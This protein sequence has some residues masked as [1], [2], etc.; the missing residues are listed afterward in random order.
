MKHEAGKGNK[1]QPRNRFWQPLVVPCQP[2]ELGHPRETAL[3]HPSSGQQHKA[4]FRFW[5]F[6]HLQLNALRRCI[7]CCLFTRITLVYKGHFYILASDVLHL[8]R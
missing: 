8:L 1:M 3:H 2:P 6:H 5:Q 7:L 4:L